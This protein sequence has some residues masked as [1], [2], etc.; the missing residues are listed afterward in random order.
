MDEAA[1]IEQ[2]VNERRQRSRDEKMRL[3]SMNPKQL[4][5]DYVVTNLLSGKSYRLA[6]RGWEPGESYCAC[7]DFAKTPW[8][9]ASISSTL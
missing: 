5:T 1:L 9:P 8:A 2:A 7:P 6:L 3:T 4:W